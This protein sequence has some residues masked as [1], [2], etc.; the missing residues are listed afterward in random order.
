M[1][2]SEHKT[3]SPEIE[4]PKKSAPRNAA[5]NYI[6]SWTR[7]GVLGLTLGLGI[8][9]AADS[10]NAF[11]TNV[12]NVSQTELKKAVSEKNDLII[13][14]LLLED[15][16]YECA[17][18]DHKDGSVIE[19]VQGTDLK[20]T[21]MEGKEKVKTVLR[22][23]GKNSKVFFK[24]RFIEEGGKITAVIHGQTELDKTKAEGENNMI[25]MMGL[26]IEELGYDH[27]G[28]QDDGSVIEVIQE[29]DNENAYE[30]IE[31]GKKKVSKAL[32]KQE[33]EVEFKITH[34]KVGGKLTA[35]IWGKVKPQSIE[36]DGMSIEAEKT[37]GKITPEKLQV[38]IG[39]PHY[40][41][42][43][44]RKTGETDL[45]KLC[46]TAEKE[47]A[48]FFVKF[49]NG[50]ESWHEC[51]LEEKKET[52]KTGLIPLRKILERE[53]DI[54]EISHYHFHPVERK[55]SNDNSQTPSGKDINAFTEIIFRL[56]EHPH[57]LKK[58]DFR[59]AT[60]NGVYT[61]KINHKIIH[62]KN[63]HKKL[64]KTA[65]D[66]MRERMMFPN[67][68]YHKWHYYNFANENK[69]FAK[70]F[71]NRTMQITFNPVDKK[72][73]PAYP[74]E[75]PN[76]MIRDSESTLYHLHYIPHLKKTILVRF[77]GIAYNKT[78][79]RIGFVRPD[80]KFVSG[81][82][83]WK[84]PKDTKKFITLNNS[85][86]T[87]ATSEDM[88]TNGIIEPV[89]KVK[90]EKRE[91]EVRFQKRVVE[92]LF[93]D[94]LPKD[95]GAR[96][97]AFIKKSHPFFKSQYEKTLKRNPNLGGGKLII[98]F[99]IYKSGKVES[100]R[101]TYPNKKLQK[102]ERLEQGFKQIIKNWR[103]S[104]QNQAIDTSFSLLLGAR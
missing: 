95:I 100:I 81:E 97:K 47:E 51:G 13:M 49:K 67:F 86:A 72:Q 35:A 87:I 44:P 9:G 19:I 29:K 92:N 25:I 31:R 6:R 16:G 23:K 64:I 104:K 66:I 84:W 14:Q 26:L 102:S 53:S 52:A 28:K 83:P 4:T 70:S 75:K 38:N 41:I 3:V 24:V 98:K 85:A 73:T 39:Q 77:R 80:N 96:T 27:S 103:F 30:T 32:V 12:K 91:R 22:K 68:Q 71:S 10:A 5:I 2:N 21:L 46:E 63:L 60:S 40:I 88:H 57:L 7:T 59:I 54:L 61:F 76:G 18:D 90:I 58:L 69:R 45:V 15:L 78:G 93:S 37:T 89:E 99:R 20:K 17:G 74:V 48:W 11:E 62:N 33:N 94:K 50:E 101:F 1:N 55:A 36:S 56:Q 79:K 8:L 42:K 65:H 82:P 34:A 43:K